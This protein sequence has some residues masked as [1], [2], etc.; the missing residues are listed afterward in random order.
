MNYLYLKKYMFAVPLP[1]I[2]Q[3]L[4]IENSFDLKFL[5]PPPLSF[6]LT[7]DTKVP[8]PPILPWGE[9]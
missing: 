1:N 9:G 7:R 2:S 8:P 6:T 3:H 4:R 5:P